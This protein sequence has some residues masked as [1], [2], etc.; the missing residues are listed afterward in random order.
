MNNHI[1]LQKVAQA[2]RMFGSHS[3]EAAMARRGSSRVFLNRMQ[4]A[5]QGDLVF[6]VTTAYRAT[7]D[8]H[9]NAVG[10]LVDQTPGCSRI[11]TLD[12]RVERWNNAL[13]Y[14]IPNERE[15][16]QDGSWKGA[17]VEREQDCELDPLG[18]LAR[19]IRI[20]GFNCYE[21][22]I[23]PSGLPRN[24]YQRMK[25]PELGDLVFEPGNA[26]HAP[27]SSHIDAVGFLIETGT[28]GNHV[29]K[30]H[31]TRI[32]TLDGREVRWTNASFLASPSGREIVEQP[33]GETIEGAVCL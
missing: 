1:P 5:K 8:Q 10:Y 11:T 3:S 18:H 30:E 27:D 33:P 6:E 23:S 15:I 28:V 14:A 9:I 25:H 20:F 21:V 26:I 24:L 32:L 22:M 12:G 16:G 29:W 13:F 19:T 2:I 7:D 17:S 4:T 31:F